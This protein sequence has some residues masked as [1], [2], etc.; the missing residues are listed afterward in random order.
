MSPEI[1]ERSFEEAIEYGLTQN[2][3]DASASVPSRKS[4]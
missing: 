4:L 3:P 2:G 1:S